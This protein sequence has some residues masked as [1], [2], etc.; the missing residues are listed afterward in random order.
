VTYPAYIIDLLKAGVTGAALAIV[1]FLVQYTVSAPWWMD[2]VGRTVVAKDAALLVLLGP[3]CL[4]IFWPSLVSPMVIAW[5]DISAL[6]LV[7]TLMAWRC[8]VWYRIQ[9]P[10]PLSIRKNRP[11]STPMGDKT[12]GTDKTL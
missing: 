12:P 8:V 11:R 5:A 2:P 3:N 6:F 4:S 1:L 9:R 10:W 7:T